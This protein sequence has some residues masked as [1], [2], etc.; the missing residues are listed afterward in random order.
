MT[1]RCW[2]G[3]GVSKPPDSFEFSLP[4]RT[5]AGVRT[6]RLVANTMAVIQRKFFEIMNSLRGEVSG[7]KPHNFA[8]IDKPDGLPR[9]IRIQTR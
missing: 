4:A 9:G 2:I 7:L 1:T 5:P 3:V 8:G 6:A